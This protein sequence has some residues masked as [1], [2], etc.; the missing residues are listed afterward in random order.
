MKTL[1]RV[2]RGNARRRRL[3][4]ENAGYSE[5]TAN[6]L[7]WPGRALQIFGGPEAKTR[8]ENDR[9]SLAFNERTQIGAGNV[10]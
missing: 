5:P 6:N 2:E 3:L 7:A 8:D 9:A 10:I 4:Y 1:A